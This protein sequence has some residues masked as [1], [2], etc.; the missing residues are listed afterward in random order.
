MPKHLPS[1]VNLIL[2]NGDITLFISFFDST[3]ITHELYIDQYF[4]KSDNELSS[5][6]KNFTI[7]TISPPPDEFPCLGQFLFSSLK[8]KGLIFRCLDGL[9][10][11]FYYI[12]YSEFKDEMHFLLILYPFSLLNPDPSVIQ[13]LFI[14]KPEEIQ[15]QY[16]YSSW[17][18]KYTDSLSQ[19]IDLSSSQKAQKLILSQE[20]KEKQSGANKV[21]NK[22]HKSFGLCLFCYERSRNIV[23]LPCGHMAACLQCSVRKLKVEITQEPQSIETCPKCPLCKQSIQSSI[24]VLH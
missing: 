21:Q 10:E 23:F 2:E 1:A 20:L 7:G 12:I 22:S 19:Y 8:D 17:I 11:N 24:E 16:E 6:Y 4:T 15:Y 13:S 5:V 9:S 3:H 18:M 14:L